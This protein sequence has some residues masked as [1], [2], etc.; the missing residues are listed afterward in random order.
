MKIDRNGHL[1][2]YTLH[3]YSLQHNVLRKSYLIF[4]KGPGCARKL[5]SCRKAEDV[6]GSEKEC[7]GVGEE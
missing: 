2:K 7:H 6:V 3:P 5:E 1:F 4:S